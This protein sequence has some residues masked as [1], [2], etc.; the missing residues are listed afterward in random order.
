MTETALLLINS[1]AVL[2]S[3]LEQGEWQ[4]E[5]ASSLVVAEKKLQEKDYP[6]VLVVIEHQQHEALYNLIAQHSG[7]LWI[8][9]IQRDCLASEALRNLLAACFHD[10]HTFP[11]DRDRLSHSLGHALGWRASS[12]DTAPDCNPSFV[13]SKGRAPPF[14]SCAT[15]S[16]GCSIAACPYW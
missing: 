1:C 10:F 2:E 4:V 16:C 8:G 9:L 11:L 6:L 13:S 12:G 3:L 15:R 5:Q 7:A 14:A